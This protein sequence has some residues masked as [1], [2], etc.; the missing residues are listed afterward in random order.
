LAPA[1]WEFTLPGFPT[2]EPLNLPLPPLRS[3]DS[4]RYL[5]VND[6]PTVLDESLYRVSMA[7][8]PGAIGILHT[9]QWPSWLSVVNAVIVRYEA[10]YDTLPGL[11]HAALLTLIDDFYNQRDIKA[12]MTLTTLLNAA[13]FGDDFGMY[14]VR[15]PCIPLFSAWEELAAA[16]NDDELIAEDDADIVV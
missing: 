6:S 2:Y 7:S 13:S 9:G 10:G 1:T 11:I 4:V 14:G 16:E 3:V 8:E 15:P 12:D 5:D